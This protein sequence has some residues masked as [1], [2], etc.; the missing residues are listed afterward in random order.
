[1]VNISQT[2]PFGPCG[3]DMTAPLRKALDFIGEQIDKRACVVLGSPATLAQLQDQDPKLWAM[4]PTCFT[5]TQ[6]VDL[7]KIVGAFDGVPVGE[8]KQEGLPGLAIFI[9]DA[10]VGGLIENTPGHWLGFVEA[11]DLARVVFERQPD[12]CANPNHAPMN[13][14]D[15]A[16]RDEFA[17]VIK[18]CRAAPAIADPARIIGLFI[19]GLVHVVDLEPEELTRL[20]IWAAMAPSADDATTRELF[21]AALKVRAQSQA[22]GSW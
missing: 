4:L 13:V 8:A 20:L 19:A 6:H 3:P 14:A 18:Q 2:L 16:A 7:Y 12:R 17:D 15:T 9:D 21:E 5:Q 11:L 22:D 10:R 1:M